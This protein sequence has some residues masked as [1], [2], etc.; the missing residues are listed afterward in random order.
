MEPRKSAQQHGGYKK[1]RPESEN[2]SISYPL[3]FPKEK[4]KR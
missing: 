4:E 1:G 2:E 3:W